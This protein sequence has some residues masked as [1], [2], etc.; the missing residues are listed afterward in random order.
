MAANAL[1][2][3]R[4]GKDDRKFVLNR[5]DKA[6][7]AFWQEVNKEEGNI[8]EK[9]F[10]AG[11]ILYNQIKD[12]EPSY[13]KDFGKGSQKVSFRL[14]DQGRTVDSQYL[15]DKEYQ[16]S[17]IH[18]RRQLVPSGS[19]DDLRR[20]G[21]SVSSLAQRSRMESMIRYRRAM[22]PQVCLY[23]RG[24]RH[25]IS[26]HDRAAGRLPSTGQVRPDRGRESHAGDRLPVH[27]GQRPGSHRSSR[28]VGRASTWPS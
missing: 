17:D 2:S 23:H 14:T 1:A 18:V 5:V 24:H 3:L 22:I 7:L 4:K 16:K 11:E 25:I 20:V 19:A 8:E 10:R 6:D 12:K 21:R 28:A 9:G 26:S 27:R 15:E 13:Y